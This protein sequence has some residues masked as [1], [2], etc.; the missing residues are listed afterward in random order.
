MSESIST[1]QET[2]IPT[3]SFAM[4]QQFSQLQTVIENMVS[5]ANKYGQ[6][7]TKVESTRLRK[8]LMTLAK[9]WKNSRQC[10]LQDTKAL[11][12]VPRTSK[13]QPVNEE[14]KEEFIED[15][16]EEVVNAG[17]VKK[18]RKPRKKKE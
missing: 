6:K 7:P 3:S 18:A 2:Q 9:Q 1:I 4:P 12:K 8:H 11:P 16:S 13:K 17:K 15:A 10:I 5:S 14:R